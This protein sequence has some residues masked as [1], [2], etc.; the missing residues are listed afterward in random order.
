MRYQLELDID[1]PRERV[2]ELFLDPASL[3]QWQ[4]DLVSFEPLGDGDPRDVG[5]QSRQVH[6]MGGREVEIL[7]TITVRDD[8]EKFAATYEADRV[9]N[10]V[11]NRFLDED[12]QKTRWILDSEFKCSGMA[13]LMA[14]F[15]PGVFKKQTL[16]FMKRFKA[17]A[18]DAGG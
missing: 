13:K 3:H 8:P 12:G 4:P 2:V 17:F 10:L 18:E 14:F 16:T 7:E 9:W 15:M 5:A 6:R 1:V 11:E